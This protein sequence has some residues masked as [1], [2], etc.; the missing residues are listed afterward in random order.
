MAG[1]M[2][3]NLLLPEGARKNKKIEVRDQPAATIICDGAFESGRRLTPT[4]SSKLRSISKPSR[5]FAVGMNL[6]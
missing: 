4:P 6:L 3:A 2:S 1:G 5:P